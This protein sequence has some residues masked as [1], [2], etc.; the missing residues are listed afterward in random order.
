MDAKKYF[1]GYFENRLAEGYGFLYE[2]GVK[3]TSTFFVKGYAEGEVDGEN[4]LERAFF[5][6]TIRNRKK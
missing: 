1:C 3:Q 4:L 6:Y 5:S 2:I